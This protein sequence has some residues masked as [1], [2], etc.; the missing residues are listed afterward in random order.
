MD[1]LQSLWCESTLIAIDLE[2]T[3]KYPLDA[4][5][6]EMAAV[7]WR[8]GQ[9]IDSFQSLIRPTS[10]M[11][12]EVLAIHNITNE[13]VETAP[14]LSEKISEFHRFISEGWILAHHAPFDMGFL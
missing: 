4:E 13:M 14:T 1:I 6:C 2:T 7:K 10:A 9:I 12:Q 11:P 8:N 3:G 5:I